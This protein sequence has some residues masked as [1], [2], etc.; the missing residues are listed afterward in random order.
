MAREERKW[1]ASTSVQVPMRNT[2]AEQFVVATKLAKAG[3]AKGLRRPVGVIG[4]PLAG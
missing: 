4:Q 1:M 2:G 3:G